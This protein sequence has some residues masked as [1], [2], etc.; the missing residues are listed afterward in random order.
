MR[1]VHIAFRAPVLQAR[2]LCLL[3]SS[4]SPHVRPAAPCRFLNGNYYRG[5]G[6]PKL[7]QGPAHFSVKGLKV[8]G[9]DSGATRPLSQLLTS[10]SQRKSHHGRS[11]NGGG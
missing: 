8:N 2:V 11:T 7:H 3:V 6:E 1:R 5:E 4:R 10:A 9:V